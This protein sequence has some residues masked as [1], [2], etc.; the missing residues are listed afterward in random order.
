MNNIKSTSQKLVFALGF[1]ATAE[2]I[3]HY[4]SQFPDEFPEEINLE[5]I[6]TYFVMLM[7]EGGNFQ[8]EINPELRVIMENVEIY[9]NNKKT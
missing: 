7:L 8:C 3:A 1:N 6:I 4:I 5:N 2:V 9:Y